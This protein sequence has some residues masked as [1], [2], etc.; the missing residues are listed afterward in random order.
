[1]E[2]CE[3]FW[4]KKFGCLEKKFRRWYRYGTLTLVSVPY[5]ETWFRSHTNPRPFEGEG[6]TYIPEKRGGGDR[7]PYPPQF[8]RHC[9]FTLAN[10]LSIWFFFLLQ[11]WSSILAKTFL[12]VK[13]F[14]LPCSPYVFTENEFT[15]FHQFFMGRKLIMYFCWIVTMLAW[16]CD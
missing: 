13:E 5:T 4:K 9:Y 11:L 1:M 12:L 16:P 8:Q 15:N 14:V 6:F 7:P 10:S 3:N 2:K